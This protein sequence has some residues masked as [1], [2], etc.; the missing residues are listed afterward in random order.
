MV[1]GPPGDPRSLRQPPGQSAP[2]CSPLCDYERFRAPGSWHG[3][4]CPA[5]VCRRCLADLGPGV[6]R[7]PQTALPRNRA[8]RGHGRRGRGGRA[9]NRTPVRRRRGHPVRVLGRGG[10]GRGGAGGRCQRAF[11]RRRRRRAAPDANVGRGPFGRGP[12]VQLLLEPH[13]LLRG[14]RESNWMASN[15]P[16]S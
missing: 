7:P 4:P 13:F 1:G 16:S 15:G 8:G 5:C 10:V 6:R 2:T 12:G 3:R 14:R 11:T 9:G